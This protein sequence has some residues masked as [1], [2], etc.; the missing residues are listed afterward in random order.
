MDNSWIS[1]ARRPLGLFMA[2]ASAVS[3]RYVM[4]SNP[5]F[6][7]E[8]GIID[9]RPEVSRQSDGTL[10]T[11]RGAELE[12]HWKD[13]REDAIKELGYDPVARNRV[14]GAI[15]LAA[16]H[17]LT[18]AVGRAATP[19]IGRAAINGTKE[20]GK[21]A[22]KQINAAN[23]GAIRLATTA[24]PKLAPYTKV[25][26]KWLPRVGTTGLGARLLDVGTGWS[27]VNESD[28]AAVKGLKRT[29]STAA[30][31]AQLG[32]IGGTAVY[33]GLNYLADRA[34]A[35][36]IKDKTTSSITDKDIKDVMKDL[37]ETDPKAYAAIM[38]AGGSA[39][40]YNLDKNIR[41]NGTAIS[42]VY[43]KLQSKF[44]DKIPEVGSDI[45]ESY[46]RGVRHLQ[47]A[48]AGK[49]ENQDNV[50]AKNIGKSIL[51][52][53]DYFYD[54]F[55]RLR[56]GDYSQPLIKGKPFFASNAI[57]EGFNDLLKNYIQAEGSKLLD[58]PEDEL[59]ILLSRAGIAGKQLAH[60][61]HDNT[62]NKENNE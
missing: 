56:N 42:T 61:I 50:V 60:K 30:S 44:P 39:Y 43:Q 18:W 25:M 37:A 57:A 53:P 5:A 13:L 1:W 40:G 33:T 46:Q 24:F 49:L 7:N 12:R 47:D 21:G 3:P 29:A 59:A 19:I 55:G 52:H 14:R 23:N 35:P 34:I 31:V 28:N 9:P 20:V 54:L 6:I 45:K 16:M 2:K 38:L 8:D 58:M 22:L 11:P 32:N 26:Q 51:N 10:I 62:S 15:G 48:I 41:E 4:P 17:P 36:F 27:H